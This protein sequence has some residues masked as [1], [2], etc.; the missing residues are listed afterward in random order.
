[1]H[2][3]LLDS[4]LIT[5]GPFYNG[6]GS[7]SF[8]LESIHIPG[9]GFSFPF[10]R[11]S[12][13]TT[14]L[15]LTKCLTHQHSILHNTASDQRSHFATMEVQ[16]WAHGHEMHWSHH[17]PHHPEAASWQRD[18][19]SFEDATQAAVVRIPREHRHPGSVY[20]LNPWSLN[21]AVST[22]KYMDATTK[23]RA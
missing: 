20:S 7:N 13:N 19:W 6:R 3:Q 1:M 8:L 22:V 9:L 14:M 15:G 5:L 16:G 10:Y 2:H 23:R 17:I 4:K 18:G 21:G 11:V 12:L